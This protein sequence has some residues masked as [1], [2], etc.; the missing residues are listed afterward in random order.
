MQGA[1]RE[2]KIAALTNFY[3]ELLRIHPFTDGNGRVA[4]ALFDQ[5][6][7]ELLQHSVLETTEC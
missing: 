3:Y 2:D 4:D 5:A 6:A 7:R 1:S